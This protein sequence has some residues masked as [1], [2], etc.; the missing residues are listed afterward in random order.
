[1]AVVAAGMGGRAEA[2]AAGAHAR[3]EAALDRAYDALDRGS[4]EQAVRWF[5]EAL[6]EDPKL[7]EAWGARGWVYAELGQL[8]QAVADYTQALRLEPRD[9]ETWCNRGHARTKLGQI[10][11]AIA[12]LNRALQL[13]PDLVEGYH[14][15]AWA[16]SQ[17]GQYEKA[18]VDYTETLRRA[19]D[20]AYL[21]FD[22]AICLTALKRYGEALAD[23]NAAIR[24]EPEDLRFYGARG[25]VRVYL[26]DCAGGAEDLKRAIRMN[27]R[28]AGR[29]YSA[30]PH[31]ELSAEALAHGRR[32][33]EQ[34]LR[35]RPAMAEMGQQAGFLIE[36]AQRKFAGEDAGELIDWDPT[37]P[38]H[39]DAENIAPSAGR[40]ARIRVSAVY[41]WGPK[42]G[43]K[44]GFEEL[45]SNVVFELHNV[46]LMPYFRQLRR[47]AENG[48]ISKEQFVK[49][50]WTYEHRAAQQ[51]RAF[52]V[53]KYLPW[54]AKHG[55]S[56]DPELWFAAYWEEAERTFEQFTD[57]SDY[58][59]R[60]YARQYDWA[61]VRRTL[62][63]LK[64]PAEALQAAGEAIAL[65]PEYATAYRVR[66]A[67]WQQLGE[68]DK[69]RADLQR[70]AEIERR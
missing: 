9:A 2:Q 34:M 23:L 61:T 4:Y 66:G 63:E 65:A 48:R 26:G 37:P 50:M 68:S 24:L 58:P 64:R 8:E 69:A 35:D 56:S 5:G 45:W 44:R 19:G 1:M 10:E 6:R 67:A 22:R 14:A 38:R 7:A 33:V 25:A 16:Y 32:Q 3:A 13:D 62:L 49:G 60:P 18:V 29:S 51:T 40:H 46:V 31:G 15:R 53:Q 55:L 21:R 70:A 43:Q 52:Y 27:P 11:Q 41:L 54:A 36:W 12:D 59:W 47:Q 20:D 39:S 28:D 30:E 17:A 42:R 57:R